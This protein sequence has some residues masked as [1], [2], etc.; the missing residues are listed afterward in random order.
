MTNQIVLPIQFRREP[1]SVDPIQQR[2]LV[3]DHIANLAAEAASERMASA[4]RRAR[5]GHIEERPGGLHVRAALG[6]ALIGSGTA[7]AAP[8]R[9]EDPSTDVGAGH[10]A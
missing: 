3:N 4:A 5:P 8:G 10:P 2:H 9:A 6:C 1:P 7:I